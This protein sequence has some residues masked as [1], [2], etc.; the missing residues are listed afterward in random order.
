MQDIALEIKAV[1]KS[2][3]TEEDLLVVD[4]INLRIHKGEAFGFLGSNGA[5][6]TTTIKMICGLITPTAGRIYINGYDV[7]RERSAAMRQ[8]GV[9]LEGTRNIYWMLSAWQNL[10]YFGRLKGVS[11]KKSKERG[12]QLLRELALWER[13]DDPISNFSR[14]M[15]QRVAIACAL[16]AD[17]PILILDEPTLGLDVEATQIVKALLTRLVQDEH[18]TIIITSHQLDVVQAV[19]QRVAIIHK[20]KIIADKSL[21]ELLLRQDY[22]H[23]KF[24]GCL[25]SVMWSRLKDF[26]ITENEGGTSL[27]GPVADL[28]SLNDLLDDLRRRGLVLISVSPVEPDLE[29]MFLTLVKEIS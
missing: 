27:I 10:L 18:K 22:Y 28:N 14:G 26:T 1:T 8:I 23:I 3:K 2:F 21:A 25:D 11:G 4:D 15:Q 29:E 7:A 24:Q 17:P 9:V 20:G 6:K 13:R 19:C 5:G 12:E 16:I